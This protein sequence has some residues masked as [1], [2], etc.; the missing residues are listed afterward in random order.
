MDRL[1]EL[2]EYMDNVLEFARDEEKKP[3]RPIS[4]FVTSPWLP[5]AGF[6]AA[7]AGAGVN[8][9]H[10]QFLGKGALRR[11]P[12]GKLPRKAKAVLAAGGLAG[13]GI[14]GGAGYGAGALRNVIARRGEEGRINKMRKKRDRLSS[15]KRRD[16]VERKIAKRAGRY[17]E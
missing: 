17:A 4:R 14:M 8:Q 13:A 12:N 1:L 2:N 10:R 6:G 5:A 3:T 7:G 15:G 16:R 9:A 11:M